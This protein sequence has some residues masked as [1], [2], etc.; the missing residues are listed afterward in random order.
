MK[1]KSP[2]TLSND[3]VFTLDMETDSTHTYQLGNGIV[4]HNSTSCILGSASG[5][6]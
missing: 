3:E 5:I 1:V 6:H 2:P 4:S